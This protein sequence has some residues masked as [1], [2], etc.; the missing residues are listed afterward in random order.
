[1]TLRAHSVTLGYAARDVVV[2]LD[3]EISDGRLTVLVGPNGCGKSTILRGLAGLLPCRAGTVRVDDDDLTGLAPKALARRLSILPQHPTT[4]EGLAVKELVARGRYPHQG[5]FSA[6]RESDERAVVAALEAVGLED[7]ASAPL[8]ELSGGQRQR[9]WVAMV[10]AQDTRHVLLDEPT[11]FLDLAHAVEV[12]EVVR[13]AARSSG[14]AVV[15]VLHDLTLAARF[16][17]RIVV[18]GGGRI[19]ASGPPEGVLT[20]DLLAEVF[21]LDAAVAL[22]DG[23]PAV[24]PRRRSPQAVSVD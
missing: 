6:W 16:A 13:G 8:E 3:L 19:V 10:L 24:V 1:M 2:D 14:K 21:D 5:L 12:M 18:V 23:A 17:D 11:T 7:L 9:T 15:A 22:I 4:P 20:E